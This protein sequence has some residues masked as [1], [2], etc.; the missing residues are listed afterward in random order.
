MA[1]IESG[2]EIEVK[3]VQ[4]LNVP[5]CMTAI[6]DEMTADAIDR[7]LSN[8]RIPMRLTESGMVIDVSAPQQ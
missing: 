6:E 5:F 8:A 7:Q 4:V 3:L 1:M 2:I